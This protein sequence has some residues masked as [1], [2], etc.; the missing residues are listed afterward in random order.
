MQE[1]SPCL[2]YTST[3]HILATRCARCTN[4]RGDTPDLNPLE[5]VWNIM[6]EAVKDSLSIENCSVKE[7]TMVFF[8]KETDHIAV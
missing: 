4:L 8:A 3:E 7:S 6:T 5:K 2:N 1:N